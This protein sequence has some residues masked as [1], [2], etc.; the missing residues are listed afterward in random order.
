MER[1]GFRAAIRM[2]SMFLSAALVIFTAGCTPSTLDKVTVRAR[3]E[4]EATIRRLDADWVKIAAAKDTDAWV[5]FYAGDAIVLPPNGKAMKD[6]ATIRKSI[7]DLLSLPDLSVSWEPVKVEVS[8][9]G[10]LAYLYGAYSLTMTGADGK[11]VTDFGK[12]VEIWKK[13]SNGR[14]RCIVDTWNSDIPASPPV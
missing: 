5:A 9:A 13:Q 12:N 2:S 1:S 4:D 8:K 14:W 6:K 7:S 3:A 11:P 10:D